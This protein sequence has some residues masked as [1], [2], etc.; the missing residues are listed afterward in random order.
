M[1]GV[2]EDEV[3]VGANVRVIFEKSANGQ[4]IPEWEVVT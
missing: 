1:P 4:L 3:P 2:P